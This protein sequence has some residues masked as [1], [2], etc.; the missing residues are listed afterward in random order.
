[1]TV[2]LQT[3]EDFNNLFM[4]E[5]MKRLRVAHGLSTTQVAK[6]LE[7]TR[8]S[9]AYYESGEREI[10]IHDIIKLAH[11]YNVSVDALVGNPFTNKSE[12][13]LTFWSYEV[14]NGAIKSR[15][16][17]TISTITDD[18]IA[19]KVDELTIEFYWKTN[20]YQQGH[21]M[22]F[23]YYN[24]FYTAKVYYNKD[25]SGFF[26]FN[27]EVIKFTKA[28]GENLLYKGVHMGKLNKE[29]VIPHFF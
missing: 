7:K 1:M 4:R 18:V 8:Q 12:T 5:N 22:L 19:L 27:N 28:N 21:V 16:P 10:N 20:T 13:T 11:F 17:I 24:K 3:D 14:I 25:K 2:K 29:F 15:N 6:V 23:E 9:Y 26:E